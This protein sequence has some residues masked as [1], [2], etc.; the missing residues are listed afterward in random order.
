MDESYAQQ[1]ES[2]MWDEI[3]ANE[4]SG[5]VTQFSD[6]IVKNRTM[7]SSACPATY[8]EVRAAV[9]ALADENGWT[10]VEAAAVIAQSYGLRVTFR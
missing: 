9:K 10:N 5:V 3:A 4:P 2:E 8:N 7:L 6:V 1:A